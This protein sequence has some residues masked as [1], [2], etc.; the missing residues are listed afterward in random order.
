MSEINRAGIQHQLTRRALQNM[1]NNQDGK[2]T[3]AELKNRIKKVDENQDGKLS[4]KEARQ[5]GIQDTNDISKL[6]RLLHNIHTLTPNEVVFQPLKPEN[7]Q[8]SL[9]KAQKIFDTTTSKIVSSDHFTKGSLSIK[10]TSLLAVPGVA[11]N[12]IISDNAASNLI[13]LQLTSD[14][15]KDMATHTV[16]IKHGNC[17]ELAC[18]AAVAADQ[19]GAERVELFSITNHLFVVINRDPTSDA[20]NPQ[21]WGPEA[22][23]MDPWADEG[24][25][26]LSLAHEYPFLESPVL[27]L[28]YQSES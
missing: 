14:K 25:G 11:A 4:R 27:Q 23:I 2:T 5:L 17:A 12:R 26:K 16:L 19:E 24:Q 15:V 28:H 10:A 13:G 3:V 9:S 18:L 6:N 22:I 20:S 7:R 8:F 1:D 21:T